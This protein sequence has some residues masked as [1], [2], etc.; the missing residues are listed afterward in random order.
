MVGGCFSYQGEGSKIDRNRRKLILDQ[1]QTVV[2]V[3]NSSDMAPDAS[4]DAQGPTKRPSGSWEWR[5][6][7]GKSPSEQQI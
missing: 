4:T 5:R 2:D 7:I 6:S 3:T 1:Y